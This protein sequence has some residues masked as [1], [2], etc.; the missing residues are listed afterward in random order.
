MIDADPACLQA[1]VSRMEVVYWM[2]GPRAEQ[3]SVLPVYRLEGRCH[4][5]SGRE[6]GDFQ[7]YAPAVRNP[8]FPTG[9]KGE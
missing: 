7:A 3:R 9:G 8:P 5:A 1:E 4:D 6:T 2:E